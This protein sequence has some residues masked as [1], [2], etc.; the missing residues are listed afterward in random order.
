MMDTKGALTSWR[1]LEAPDFEEFL[2]DRLSLLTKGDDVDQAHL[3]PVENEN[4]PVALDQ[5]N[6]SS[7]NPFKTTSGH[8]FSAR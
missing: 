1:D 4:V 6:I 8:T 5:S 3:Q 7:P 2:H